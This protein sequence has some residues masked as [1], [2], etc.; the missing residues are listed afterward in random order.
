MNDALY[1]LSR[2][3]LLPQRIAGT[4]VMAVLETAG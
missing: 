3:E 1:Q 2:C 4:S